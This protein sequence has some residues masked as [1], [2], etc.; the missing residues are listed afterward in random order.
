MQVF[1]GCCS[2][3]SK[4]MVRNKTGGMVENKAGPYHGNPCLDFTLN[5]CGNN[6]E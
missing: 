2:V 5:H 1:L 4:G 3:L 6:G